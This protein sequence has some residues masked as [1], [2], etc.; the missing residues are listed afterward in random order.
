[1]DLP[2]INVQRGRDHA[3]QPYIKYRELCG[4]GKVRTWDDMKSLMED[5]AVDALKSV[6]RLAI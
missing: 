2:A 5:H 3:V 1:M 6:Y 4:F